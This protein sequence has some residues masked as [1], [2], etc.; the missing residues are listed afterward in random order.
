MFTHYTFC[1]LIIHF[2]QAVGTHLLDEI[3][4]A[5]NFHQLIGSETTALAKMEAHW[6]VVE[7]HLN[8]LYGPIADATISVPR[9]IKHIKHIKDIKHSLWPQCGCYNLGTQTH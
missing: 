5:I 3:S 6:G 8:T 9:H 7:K 4:Q 1:S 2:V